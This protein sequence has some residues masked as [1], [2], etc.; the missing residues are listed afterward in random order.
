MKAAGSAQQLQLRKRRPPQAERADGD[1]ANGSNVAPAAPA[2]SLGLPPP[3]PRTPEHRE[4]DRRH[5]RTTSPTP[6]PAGP[7]RRAKREP[8]MQKPSTTPLRLWE[9]PGWPGAT[10]RGHAERPRPDLS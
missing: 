2:A 3:A 5:K 9:H 8:P 7:G 6:E 10:E 1:C 4:F